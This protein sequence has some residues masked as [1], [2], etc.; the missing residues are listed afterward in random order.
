M[1]SA[2]ASLE[3]WRRDPSLGREHATE[4]P[5][6]FPPRLGGEPQWG[7]NLDLPGGRD[8]PAWLTVAGVLAGYGVVLAVVLGALFLVPY[9]LWTVLG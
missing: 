1:C 3:R 8:H 5:S 4:P 2:H 7:M 9:A 6:F